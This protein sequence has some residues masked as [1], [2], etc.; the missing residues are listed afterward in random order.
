MSRKLP[1]GWKEVKLGDVLDY[2]QPTPYL[3]ASTD[4]KNEYKTP[5]LTAGKSFLLG[6]TDE[7]EGIFSRHKLPVII[8]DDFT[9]A[10]KFVD[11]PFKVKSSAMKILVAK[12]DT[13]TYFIFLAMQTIK[14]DATRHKRYW[15]SQYSHLKIPLPPLPEQKAIAGTLQ[16]WDEAIEKTEALIKAKQKRFKGLAAK[17][18]N[19]PNQQMVPLHKLATEL[20]VSN[21][22]RSISRILSVTNRSGFELPTD[23]FARRIASDDL[24]NYKVVKNGQYAYNPS[25]INVGSIARLDEWP[26]G[27][28][29][30]MYV[31]FE[32]NEVEIASDYFLHWLS[33]SE[34]R[35]RIRNSAQ[36]SVRETVPFGNL[37]AIRIPLPPL[38]A[39][40]AI[41]NILNTAQREIE[42][43]EQ[44]ADLYRNQQRG[45][46]QLLLTGTWRVSA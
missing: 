30:P 46:M 43:L 28:L 24:A 39:Q 17:F 40:E 2:E 45:L 27:V 14:F 12:G 20:S 25:R 37:A 18:I 35:Q 1:S 22:D 21:S 16:A 10:T 5:V 33:S 34:A 23:R 9:T 6:Y 41:A 19:Q 36:G 3:V 8:F 32:L 11:F 29:S 42:L 4:Y 38:P 44:L 7:T 13:N 15:I 26:A 31:V